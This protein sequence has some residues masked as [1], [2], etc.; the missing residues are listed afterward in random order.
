M[1][2]FNLPEFDPM[3]ISIGH[4]GIRWYALAYITGLLIGWRYCLWLAKR[5]PKIVTSEHIDDL[6]FWV[7]L[8]VLIGGRL[9]FVLFYN[10][11]YYSSHP[12]EILQIWKGGMSF[13]GGLIGVMAAIYWYGKRKGTGFLPMADL[14][15]A[16][17]PVGLF[18]GRLGN[19]V[20]GELWGR[21]TDLPW[22]VIYPRGGPEPR[23]PTQLY[24]A[25]LE[26]IVLFVLLAWLVFRRDALIRP[27]LISGAFLTGYAVARALAETVRAETH[28]INQFPLGLSYGQ[29]LSIP[30]LI[31]GIF[32]LRRAL[33]NPPVLASDHRSR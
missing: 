12:L 30:M 28:F 26:G 25:G 11:G 6:F 8:G 31:L 22:G 18:L 4:Y 14:L 24:E 1:G 27:G 21:V 17:V 9:G 32:L 10:P 23:H 20:N 16:A 29:L 7:T 3:A 2:P 15:A 19:F 5:P 33:A 13:H